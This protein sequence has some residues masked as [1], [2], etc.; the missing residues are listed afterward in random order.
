MQDGLDATVDVNSATSLNIPSS[1]EKPK[2]SK[3]HPIILISE[4][5]DLLNLRPPG[6]A[7]TFKSGKTDYREVKLVGNN[8]NSKDLL[9]MM[10]RHPNTF[11]LFDPTSCHYTNA[12]SIYSSMKK[13]MAIRY[14]GSL[15]MK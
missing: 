7:K 5:G 3:E 12:R 6:K 2:S 13:L 8:S 9:K 15:T 11:F 14:Y 4:H 1:N 10:A